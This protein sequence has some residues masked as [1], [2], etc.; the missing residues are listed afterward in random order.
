[1]TTPQQTTTNLND[2]I[3]QARAAASNAVSLAKSAVEKRWDSAIKDQEAE[4]AKLLRTKQRMK[5][6]RGRSRGR[7]H[8]K[9]SIWQRMKWFL[10]LRR[11]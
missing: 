7:L 10:R 8:M 6:E 5:E 4:N 11:W 2:Q 9:Q 1:M 3:Q